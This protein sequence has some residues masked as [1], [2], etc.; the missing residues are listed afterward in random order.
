LSD[1]DVAIG[2]KVSA[3]AEKRGLIVR[4]LGHMIVLSPPLILTPEQISE[5]TS[6]LRESILAAIEE[7]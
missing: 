2:M 4:A 7:I 5:I 6:L 1:E 3:Q